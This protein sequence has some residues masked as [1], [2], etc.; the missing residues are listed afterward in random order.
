MVTI[1]SGGPAL[2]LA[3]V[4]F[5]Y[6]QLSETFIADEI[7]ELRRQGVKVTVYTL[8]PPRPGPR[9]AA[10][11][12]SPQ[13]LSLPKSR[14]A[15]A[16]LL[17]SVLPWLARNPAGF[18][19]AVALALAARRPAV[20]G[21]LVQGAR[22]AG[23]LR[24]RPAAVIHAG[25]ASDPATVAMF[26]AS[27]AHLPFTFA[28]HAVDIF[29][30]PV[31]LAVKLRHA[32]RV[33]VISEYNRRYLTDRFGANGNM[34][35]VRCG[36]APARFRA[37]RTSAGRC[38]ELVSVCRLV[39]KKGLTAAL[40]AVHDLRRR[41]VPVHYTV[42]G[43]GP[44]EGALRA[45]AAA[46]RLGTAVTFVGPVAPATVEELLARATAFLLPCVRAADGDIDG[47]PVAILE[48]M[49]MGVPVVSSRVSGVPEAVTDDAGVLVPPGDTKALV[50]ALLEVYADWRGDQK[51][52][53]GG[54]AAVREKFLLPVNVAKWRVFLE[55]VARA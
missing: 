12:A 15:R 13:D 17:A 10:P 47:I 34:C 1:D 27:F 24:R 42:A 19:R 30:D 46:L 26:A 25:F 53:R 31:L 21:H 36:V 52:F 11:D 14:L 44:L 48:A 41:G 5:A 32:A 22:L 8:E 54:P 20:F 38:F 50:A 3:Y 40:L 2:A 16:A 9:A 45:Q 7:A 29:V 23:R 33:R 28:A 55:V 43:A 4:V 39:P 6:P 51:R 35:V 37:V 49:A 18:A